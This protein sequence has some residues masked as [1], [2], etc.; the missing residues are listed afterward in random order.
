TWQVDDNGPLPAAL[1]RVASFGDRPDDKG[2]WRAAAPPVVGDGGI[3]IMSDSV[4]GGRRILR[5][6]AVSP[7][8]DRQE[9]LI[10]DG[11][12]IR[13]II[14]NGARPAVKGVPTY[15]GCTGRS[16]RRLEVELELVAGAKFPVID[17]RRTRYG[18]GEAAA[19]LVAS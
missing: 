14:V 6:A 17:W 12:A 4:A 16:C 8:S 18:A 9:L 2:H 7:R 1:R 5:F 19:R 13:R 11:S 3:E 10:E 15:I